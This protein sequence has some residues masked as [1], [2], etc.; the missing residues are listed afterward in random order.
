VKISQRSKEK[1]KIVIRDAFD[2]W[3]YSMN[4]CGDLKK[5]LI[6]INAVEHILYKM[7]NE[8]K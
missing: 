6:R 5:D 3:F 1:I 8:R 7:I 2:S 4:K